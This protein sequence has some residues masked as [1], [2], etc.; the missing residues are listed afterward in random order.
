MPLAEDT[1]RVAVLQ[2]NINPRE[3][4]DPEAGSE[5]ANCYLR[6]SEDANAARADLVVWTEAAIP[7]P[8]RDG[9]DLVEAA[10]DATGP[11]KAHHLVGAPIESSGH[12][13]V[14][15]NSALLVS[16]EGKIVGLYSKVRPRFGAE[17]AVCFPG[18]KNRVKLHPSGDKYTRGAVH[19]VLPSP[20]GVL[21]VNICNENF[22]ADLLRRSARKGAAFLV[23]LTNDGWFLQ[24]MPLRQHFIVNPFR[25]VENKRPLVVAN[26]VGVSALIDA[27]GR[28]PVKS[29]IRTQ[30]CLVGD[31]APQR[32]R[33][34]YSRVGDSFAYGC[35]VWSVLTTTW[36]PHPELSLRRPT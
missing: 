1:V 27:Y 21:G 34:L 3:R 33:S 17:T 14:Y 16:P 32:S 5:L 24:N 19:K 9:D 18:M 28:R 36:R 12:K 23:N 8:L 13:G 22:H 15:L 29:R 7:W 25:A 30:T 26:N 20:L 35:V 4:L 10:L 2:A 6:L 31:I 11:S